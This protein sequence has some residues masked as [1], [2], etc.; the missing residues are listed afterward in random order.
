MKR[1]DTKTVEELLGDTDEVTTELLV[2]LA[3]GNR[4][5]TEYQ[6]DRRLLENLPVVLRGV[7]DYVLSGEAKVLDVAYALASLVDAIEHRGRRLT[8]S[9]EVALARSGSLWLFEKRWKRGRRL[10]GKDSS[11]KSGGLPGESL[12]CSE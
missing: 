12:S 10:A 7:C 6:D 4:A 8:T 9:R 2:E 1:T 11:I 5:D 3:H